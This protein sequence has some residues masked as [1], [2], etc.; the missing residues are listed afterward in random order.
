[1]SKDTILTSSIQD[2]EFDPD[3]LVDTDN[4]DTLPIKYN[5]LKAPAY[6]LNLDGAIKLESSEPEDLGRMVQQVHDI[7]ILD[8]KY[9]SKTIDQR[10]IDGTIHFILSINSTVLEQLLQGL[11]STRMRVQYKP[12]DEYVELCWYR[13]CKKFS[14]IK[15]DGNEC[16]FKLA[17]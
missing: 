12:T 4:A 15:N 17:L 2:Q 9:K 10:S 5:I 3:S 1:M 13:Y 16:V 6:P 14:I 7:K 8:I 11:F